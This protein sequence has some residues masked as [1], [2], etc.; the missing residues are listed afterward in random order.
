M[1][2][3]NKRHYKFNLL[4]QYGLTFITSILGFIS[5]PI[6]LNYW[7]VEQFGVWAII[8]SLAA[9]IGVS[10]LGVDVA[11][12]ILMTKSNSA[13]IKKQILNKSLVVIISSV[14]IF[15]FVILL[16]N[17][18]EP[19]WVRFLG[20]MDSQLLPTAKI[21]AIIFI[22]FLLVNLP[23][24]VISNSFSAYKKAYIN[25]LFNV[26]LG[27][28]LFISLLIIIAIK[29]TLIQYAV[30]YGCVTLL[31]NILKLSIHFLIS[32]NYSSS[33]NSNDTLT[34]NTYRSIIIT[35]GRLCLYGLAIMVST[36]IG[37]LIISNS[38]DVANVTPYQ[39][40]YR[41]YFFA[42]TILT[43]INLSA[44]P[45][46]GKEFANKNWPWLINKYNT[47][48]IISILAGGGIWLGGILFLKDIIFLWVGDQGYAGILTVILLGAWI[49][50]SCL[51]NVN[52]VVV[53]SF[54][55]TKGVP[56][57]SWGEALIFILISVILIKPI[58]IAGVAAGFLIGSLLITQ[59]ALPLLL[60]RRSGRKLKYNFRILF[61]L[62][63]AFLFFI[64][65]SYFQQIY[66]ELWYIRLLVGI[67]IFSVYLLFCYKIVPKKIL[68]EILSKLIVKKSFSGGLQ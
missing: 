43:A 11:A 5:A 49:F 13:L 16:V 63:S 21:T 40:T 12:G 61:T 15:S 9:Y 50:T 14:F 6:A 26:I 24:G 8:T 10:G 62:M 17:I 60:F 29:G 53:N 19:N 35:G 54:N 39:L 64:P 18:I 46:Y 25:N 65:I 34:D 52:Y 32:K 2:E 1:I 67:L 48:F 3:D 51:S 33:D 42:F 47:F 4:S 44:T 7:K 23:F 41:L 45:L 37:N 20:K 55:Y 27:I 57:I 66:F 38:I 36:N 59:W 58:G 31:V 56:L 68:D 28:L 22:G 30:I